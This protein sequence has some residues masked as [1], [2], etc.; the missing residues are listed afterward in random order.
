MCES[1]L[2]FSNYRPSCSFHQ[3]APIQGTCLVDFTDFGAPFVST[4]FGGEHIEVVSKN[5]SS[6]T[7]FFNVIVLP[8]QAMKISLTMHQPHLWVKSPQESIVLSIPL[9]DNIFQ[10]T[11]MDDKGFEPLICLYLTSSHA[12]DRPW[13]VLSVQPQAK[14]PTPMKVECFNSSKIK[15]YACVQTKPRSLL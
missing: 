6:Q 7:L 15:L 13:V 4:F 11:W 9:M 1:H 10:C 14:F 3:L 8:H 12:H 5:E 2:D